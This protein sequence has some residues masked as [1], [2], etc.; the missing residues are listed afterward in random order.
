MLYATQA[1]TFTD[2]LKVLSED[3]WGLS[4]S[5]QDYSNHPKEMMEKEMEKLR[6][7]SK[8]DELS[9]YRDL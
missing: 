1:K 5:L 7:K 6:R 8:G 4:L 3:T 2:F 9:A